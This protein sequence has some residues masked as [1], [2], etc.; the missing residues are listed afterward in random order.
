MKPFYLVSQPELSALYLDFLCTA[1]LTPL[2]MISISYDPTKNEKDCFFLL[3]V[4]RT[5]LCVWR[6]V[7]G[8]PARDYLYIPSPLIIDVTTTF[9]DKKCQFH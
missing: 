9:E 1:G 6:S 3:A 2:L 4:Q 7:C 8:D 5:T